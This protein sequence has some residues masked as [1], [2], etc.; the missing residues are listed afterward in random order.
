MKRIGLPSAPIVRSA[1]NKFRNRLLMKFQVL[2]QNVKALLHH[3]GA[4]KAIS[5]AGVKDLAQVDGI[6]V[7]MAEENIRMV[8]F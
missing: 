3:F 6:S 5:T 1:E 7:A 8:P 4:A 2:A